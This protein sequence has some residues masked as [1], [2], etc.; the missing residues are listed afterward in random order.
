M[1]K[2]G[3]LLLAILALFVLASCQKTT[4]NLSTTTHATTAATTTSSS[5][6][7][8]TATTDINAY[9]DVYLDAPLLVRDQNPTATELLAD[10]GLGDM[11][12]QDVVF[13]STFDLTQTGVQ[14]IQ[15][16]NN[17]TRE[18]YHIRMHVYN[19]YFVT[20]E[21]KETIFD[22]AATLSD[23][24]DQLVMQSFGYDQI[25]YE[26]N[27]DF[28]TFGTP[29]DYV[30]YVDAYD[31]DW[32]IGSYAC[33]LTIIDGE[34]PVISG[35]TNYFL[36]LGATVPDFLAGVTFSDDGT[37][38]DSGVNG[39]VLMDHPGLYTLTYYATD[40]DG[41]TTYTY[42]NVVVGDLYPDF[43]ANGFGFAFY[44]PNAEEQAQLSEYRQLLNMVFLNDT[45][46]I[47]LL[48]EMNF[49]FLP[50]IFETVTGRP[51]RSDERALLDAYRAMVIK[52]DILVLETMANRLLTQNEK[53]AVNAFY[54]LVQTYYDGYQY[55]LHR[56]LY[57]FPD[58]RLSYGRFFNLLDTPTDVIAMRLD[59]S[60][61]DQELTAYHLYK[62]YF[63]DIYNFYRTYIITFDDQ[64]YLRLI[65]DYDFS[66]DADYYDVY[67][68]YDKYLDYYES[69]QVNI[70]HRTD[71][72]LTIPSE[73]LTLLDK[74]R[75]LMYAYSYITMC[76][77]NP[78]QPMTY[79]DYMALVDLIVA[80]DSQIVYKDV[81]FNST[82]PYTF[83]MPIEFKEYYFDSSRDTANGALEDAMTT[84]LF[85]NT[86]YVHQDESVVDTLFEIQT[87]LGR[88][89]YIL[90]NQSPYATENYAFTVLGGYPLDG[91]I[92]ALGRTPTEKE[93]HYINLYR[94][95]HI[96]LH[97]SEIGY[98]YLSNEYPVDH[99]TTNLFY[100]STM[101]L[102]DTV[103]AQLD[104]YTLS[105]AE[106]LLKVMDVDSR[107]FIANTRDNYFDKFRMH[108]SLSLED[109]LDYY[110]NYY[111]LTED[112][113]ATF[114]ALYQLDWNKT[115]RAMGYLMTFKY[116]NYD[117]YYDDVKASAFEEVLQL[118]QMTI[119]QLVV[120]TSYQAQNWI[121]AL[122]ESNFATQADYDQF[123]NDKH[124]L[125]KDMA[126]N[127]LY[128]RAEQYGLWL[129][130]NS[131]LNDPYARQQ[132]IDFIVD[133]GYNTD[134][135]EPERYLSEHSDDMPKLVMNYLLTYQ[136]IQLKEANLRFVNVLYDDIPFSLY[137]FKQ[138]NHAFV[139]DDLNLFDLSD[140]DLT[141]SPIVPEFIK[142][143][144]LGLDQQQI[145]QAITKVLDQFFVSTGQAYD[146]KYYQ[147]FH[148]MVDKYPTIDWIDMLNQIRVDQTKIQQFKGDLTVQQ[149]AVYDEFFNIIL[150]RHLNE[151]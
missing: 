125:Y 58:Y 36:D 41:N 118:T 81:L 57:A 40:N 128:G 75:E 10:L 14:N 19:D 67:R 132:V 148:D 137:A 121:G 66:L 76:K 117:Y 145:D 23:V 88:L 1:K 99:Y 110:T 87:V 115:S 55:Q 127:T 68:I 122:N 42:A 103:I 8:T 97:D 100:F 2:F 46:H 74:Y 29:G 27:D 133:N 18:Y 144:V 96:S 123:L 111:H 47:V 93:M 4:T 79:D 52:D 98:V 9:S 113:V 65:K 140:A 131:L 24:E 136:R 50:A 39:T 107:L 35:V 92:S 112:E 104:T 45:Y 82:A 59:R 106:I 21:L 114:T 146:E 56:T 12:N 3:I 48:K 101:R 33:H 7:Q 105:D 119:D 83:Y 6:T 43:E 15:L 78:E 85:A 124:I 54:G 149:Q 25:R 32:L 130:E 30:L 71:F 37:I 51:M 73:D 90:M 129:R 141:S 22:I 94:E 102:I 26:I 135:F 53:D 38:V 31:N 70:F 109:F 49:M 80:G 95:R 34:V 151:L 13:D 63:Y 142:T 89:W 126:L 77:A 147:F 91:L 62:R 86:F 11:A 108:L 17:T 84:W 120:M 16:T 139:R 5:E 138:A 69:H 28:I 143:A 64:N 116:N 60:M 150:D 134:A 72:D 44:Q 61:T 20:V